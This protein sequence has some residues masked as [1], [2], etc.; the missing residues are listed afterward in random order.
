MKC[1][2]QDGG[3]VPLA[4]SGFPEAAGTAGTRTEGVQWVQDTKDLAPMAEIGIYVWLIKTDRWCQLEAWGVA[5][6]I[7]GGDSK[8]N[9]EIRGKMEGTHEQ[10]FQRSGFLV[11]L[12]NQGLNN[13]G[14]MVCWLFFVVRGS[15]IVGFVEPRVGFS[16]GIDTKELYTFGP[17]GSQGIWG[18]VVVKLAKVN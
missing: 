13:L 17:F 14:Y 5:H 15:G 7:I 9:G 16:V 10:R 8:E 6:L 4:T 11:A 3:D 2:P 1:G 18:A 12:A